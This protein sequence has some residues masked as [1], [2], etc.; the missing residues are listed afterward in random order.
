[1][2]TALY[3]AAK[4]P[5]IQERVYQEL[6]GHYKKYKGFELK[7]MN[8]LHLF[9]AFV[10]ECL[11][12]KST[13]KH[14]LKRNVMDDNGFML[15]G[16]HIPKGAILFGGTF[17]VHRN[18][19]YWKQADKFYPANFMDNQGKFKKSQ[20]FVLFGEGRRNCVGQSFAIKELFAVLSAILHRYKLIVPQEKQNSFEVPDD[21]FVT[22]PEELPMVIEK[23]E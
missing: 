20:Y 21:W 4:Y 5:E 16:Y 6:E 1:M 7:K 15:N 19:R 2:E 23:R 17:H 11:R 9:R 8:E 12:F 22:H 13:I 10:Y 18:P 14:S 3:M